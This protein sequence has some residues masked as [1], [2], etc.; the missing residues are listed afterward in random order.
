MRNPITGLWR[1]PVALL[2]IVAAAAGCAGTHVHQRNY[3]PGETW[4]YRIVRTY[5]ENGAFKREEVAE[6]VH[7]VP[8]EG[9]P[10]ERIRFSKLTKRTDAG[11]EDLSAAIAAFPAYE[12][13]IAQADNPDAL[14]LPD[15]KGWDMGV[16]GPVTDLHTF[17]VAVSPQV[18]VDKVLRPGDTH[19]SPDAPVASWANGE[20]IPVGEDCIRISITLKELRPE[21]AIY[22]TRFLPPEEAT[23]KMLKPWMD[24]PVIEGTPNNFQQQMDLGGAAAVMWGREEFVITSTVRRSDGMILEATMD[25]TL[26]LRLKVGCD[27]A[28]ATCQHELPMKIQRD[29]TLALLP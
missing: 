28:L 17:L 7:E 18:G 8:K 2:C 12:A 23:L 6:S 22:E 5:H 14:A 10:R 26:D 27:A 20:D 16:V 3:A 1:I 15:I 9:P 24:A 19:T 11:T 29:L 21:A 4:R 13:S 25:N